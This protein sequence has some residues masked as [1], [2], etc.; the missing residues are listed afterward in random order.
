MPYYQILKQRR[1]DLNLSIQDVAI[2]TRLR[3]EYVRAI[4]ENNLDI[5]SDD[6]SYVRY[7]VHGYCD[8]IGVNWNMIKDEVDANISA[9]AAARDR[10]LY[11]AQVRMMQSMPA[12]KPT[13][14]NT[15]KTRKNRK[16]S[17]L[18]SSAAKVSRHLSWGSQNKLSRLILVCAGC[19]VLLL[20]GVNYFARSAAQSSMA[21]QKIAR[22]KELKEQEAT[23]QRLADDL[24]N[25]K[26]ESEQP[27]ELPS[28]SLALADTQTP[29]VYSLTGF[30]PDNPVIHMTL[31]PSQAQE[32]TILYNDQPAF[33]QTVKDSAEYDLNAGSDGVITVVF[34]K[35][36]AG[37]KLKIDDLEIPE[38]CMALDS[39]GQTRLQFQVHY[40]TEPQAASSETGEPEDQNE[41]GQTDL[42]QPETDPGVLPE[43][44]EYDAAMGGAAYDAGV[45]EQPVDPGMAG[46]AGTNQGAAAGYDPS[47]PAGSA[48]TEE[49]VPDYTDETVYDQEGIYQ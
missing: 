17:M 9:C 4:E 25:R 35:A 1:L 27:A 31:M 33:S 36:S 40:T 48:G 5:F 18:K 44:N 49:Y 10:A 2:Q 19:A 39:N 24:K 32:V 41:S 15:R 21:E 46:A 42:M 30:H 13:R 20:A 12:V 23:T 11:Q 38:T 22:E 3:P 14:K 7:F 43:G 29:G 8:A 16:K 47:Q 37:N 45:Y 28:S 26:G 6:F 34:S